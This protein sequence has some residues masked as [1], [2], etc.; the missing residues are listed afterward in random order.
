MRSM[1]NLN[2]LRKIAIYFYK[3]NKSVFSSRL[4]K[5]LKVDVKIND[6]TCDLLEKG[7]LLRSLVVEI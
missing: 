3:N 5:S 4:R 7:T 6:M 1:S 2:T